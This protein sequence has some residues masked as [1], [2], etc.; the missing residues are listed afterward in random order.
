[1][2]AAVPIIG[3]GLGYM[4]AR[5]QSKAA[6]SAAAGQQAA[7]KYAADVSYKASQ[8]ANQLQED[9]FNQVMEQSNARYQDAQILLAPYYNAGTW[10]LDQIMDRLNRGPQGSRS[11]D[12]S[13]T[14]IGVI[15][16]GG[17][18]KTSGFMNIDFDQEGQRALDTRVHGPRDV[19]DFPLD[20]TMSNATGTL[21]GGEIVPGVPEAGPNYNKGTVEVTPVKP[22]DVT[23]EQ[24]SQYFSEADIQ[25]AESTGGIQRLRTQVANELTRQG[26]PTQEEIDSSQGTGNSIGTMGGNTGPMI[27]GALDLL[28]DG[29]AGG[30]QVLRNQ[31]KL[32][33]PR[34]ELPQEGGFPPPQNPQRPERHVGK[35]KD[36]PPMT[37]E[38]RQ[39]EQGKSSFQIA[40]ERGSI[41]PDARPEEYGLQPDGM[42][43]LPDAQ[44]EFAKANQ[45]N[46][47][48]YAK[49]QSDRE[50]WVAENPVS[51]LAQLRSGGVAPLGAAPDSSVDSRMRSTNQN[52]ATLGG[53]SLD[54][55]QTRNM[56]QL[57]N[58]PE[59]QALRKRR[60][61]MLDS[62][63][64]SL[65][66]NE[67]RAWE[68]KIL[69]GYMDAD[70][71]V[72]LPGEPGFEQSTPTNPTVTLGGGQT[73]GSGTEAPREE[74]LV[75]GGVY[76][77]AGNYF[78]DAD[79]KPG[80][81]ST[82]Y[83]ML[84]NDPRRNLDME[85]EKSPGYDWLLNEN[86]RAIEN[87]AAAGGGVMSGRVL[88]A[89]QEN[90]TGL[91]SQDFYKYRDDA[92]RRNAEATEEFR[93]L[94]DDEH[95]YRKMAEDRIYRQRNQAQA[96]QQAEY[97]E[98]ILG[99]QPYQ[100]L[101]GLGQTSGA[102]VGSSAMGTANIM[103][104]AGQNYANQAGSNM[105]G[106]ANTAGN[107]AVSGANYAAGGQMTGANAMAN[108]YGNMGNAMI[109]GGSGSQD[110]F[111]D[112]YS[113]KGN[114]GYIGGGYF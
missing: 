76:D 91:A 46:M 94:R 48:N 25:A 16:Q 85:Y 102:Q 51:N 99:F 38:F 41:P 69:D 28:V 50:A 95:R 103:A 114:T 8:E 105:V 58:S 96:E 84:E 73:G 89:L 44:D 10:G 66:E 79:L 83:D 32:S 64:R 47:D 77:D 36:I 70:Q 100:S 86:Q 68:G 39:G 112:Y 1:M 55:P 42:G 67:R 21:G 2:G 72:S 43:F 29:D 7:T 92:G 62:I 60:M 22:E 3:A 61:E 53:E 4:G 65:P 101:A 59:D 13:Y 5:Q 14:P 23:M 52:T 11:G 88:K 17:D 9:M 106:A 57:T 110:S 15:P 24:M 40:K 71:G 109:Y 87:T 6:S 108:F 90:A 107:M 81:Y 45:I 20:L 37:R 18:P 74:A 19:K 33:P 54:T 31:Q 49:Y 12:W 93:L 35:Y 104:N 97:Q 34:G 113:S 98:Y 78:V 75:P 27:K 56:D 111:R 80:K 82:G 63:D 26:I 30:G